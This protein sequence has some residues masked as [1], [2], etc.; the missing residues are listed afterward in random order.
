MPEPII[1]HC[2]KELF[3]LYAAITDRGAAPQPRAGV[4]PPRP[5]E[6]ISADDKELIERG[7]QLLGPAFA[8]LVDGDYSDYDGNESDAEYGFSKD[9]LHL[10]GHDAERTER[11]V[12]SVLPY[13]PKWDSRRGETTYLRRT[14][15]K[16]L[17]DLEANGH[18]ANRNDMTAGV[19]DE[20]P[21]PHTW[22]K[23][24]AVAADTGTPPNGHCSRHCDRHYAVIE[25]QKKVIA[26]QRAELDRFKHN[27]RASGKRLGELKK[28][29]Q[30][31][32]F[33]GKRKDVIEAIGLVVEH[34]RQL[35]KSS[36]TLYFGDRD[37]RKDGRDPGG[38]AGA[39]GVSPHSVGIAVDL[40]REAAAEHPDIVPWRFKR[41]LD[42]E[43]GSRRVVIEFD[44]DST[45]ERDLARLTELPKAVSVRKEPLRCPDCPSARLH[46]TKAC[47]SCGQVVAEYDETPS[48]IDPLVEGFNKAP[49]EQPPSVVTGTY[50]SDFSTRP[51]AYEDGEPAADPL[52]K[53]ATEVANVPSPPLLIDL[54]ERIGWS[55]V[56][57]P[58]GMVGGS[59]QRWRA[60]CDF[61][62]PF[63]PEVY[64]AALGLSAHN[65]EG[66]QPAYEQ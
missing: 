25:T 43:T 30:A 22:P 32:S 63:W 11:T 3:A 16:A 62:P 29:R 15:A 55:E 2:Q 60:F 9:I 12:R 4:A 50:M 7:K 31:S 35:G 1:A 14:I 47:K 61:P 40:L 19:G 24:G 8:R 58:I 48:R 10:T 6:P 65:Q 5:P 20:Q 36:E 46:V 26:E 57:T 59:E 44:P 13:R 34:A 64:V 52:L 66:G 28:F 49:Q 54:A 18:D 38:I 51:P 37:A 45:V 53:A 23:M 56:P 27:D 42:P 21:S 41:K 33:S 17:A 39:A